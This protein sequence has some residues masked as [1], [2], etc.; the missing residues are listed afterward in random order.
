MTDRTRPAVAGFA[1]PANAAGASDAAERDTST[2]RIPLWS[3]VQPI[4]ALWFAA[5][6]HSPDARAQRMLAHWRTG[7]KALRFADGDLL[8]FPEPQLA[9]CETQ[10]G[11]VLC[12]DPRIVTHGALTSA[13]LRAEDLETVDFRT[14]EAAT[15]VIA[16]T[17]AA[18]SCDLLL[19]HGARVLGLRQAD[20]AALDLSQWIDIDAYA[21]HDTFDCNAAI[22]TPDV[23]RLAGRDVRD[24]LGEKIP[25]PS[26]EREAF[27]ER[28]SERARDGRAVERS[29]DISVGGGRH[30]SGRA[31]EGH[32]GGGRLRAIGQ[33]WL[34]RIAAGL[35]GGLA[36]VGEAPGMATGSAGRHGKAGGNDA[37]S[38]RARH[39][40]VAPSRWREALTRL[41][42]ASR[43]S[44]L[45]GWRQGAYLRKMLQMFEDGDLNE[46][47]RHAL[48]IDA[49]GPSRGQAFSAPGR[50]NQL[51]LSGASDIGTDIGLPDELR[52]HLRT[53]YRQ[54]FERLDRAG[55]IDE[56]LFVLA[57]LLNAKQEALD[58]LERHGRHVQAAELALAWDMP[59]ATI[60]R[61]L[62]LAGD[63]ERA[64]QVARRDGDFASAVAALEKTKPELA[65]KLRLAWGE[66]LAER[67]QWLT[68]METVWPIPQAR[69]LALH[70]LQAAEAA[71]ERLS[72]RALV[73]RAEH[74]PDTLERYGERLL[75]LADP[76]TDADARFAVTRALLETKTH[77]AATRAIAAAIAPALLADRAELRHDMSKANLRQV[78][79]LSE[80]P[81]LR[82]DA[83]EVSVPAVKA[84]AQF[85]NAAT[86]LRWDAP[87]VGLRAVHDVA[88][89][90]DHRYLVALGEAG[91]AV[92]DRR[93]KTVQSYAVPAYA[94][95]IGHSR[96]IALATAPRETLARVTRLDL[97]HHTA[98]DL[99]ATPVAFCAD[100]FDG[101]GWSVVSRNRI[102]VI[103]A[104]KSLHDVLWH[105]GDL[106]G[107]IVAARYAAGHE[108]YLIRSGNAFE[109]WNYDLSG[110]RLIS[111]E[112]VEL[113]EDALP[114]LYPHGQVLQL[115]VTEKAEHSFEIGYDWHRQ[116]RRVRLGIPAGEMAPRVVCQ[117]LTQGFLLG[118]VGERSARYGLYR[119]WDARCMAEFD[120]PAS[121]ALRMRE[122]PD[123][124]L[125]FDE[126]G[127]ILA[128]DSDGTLRDAIS[129]H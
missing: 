38:I 58:Y 39:E 60:V 74:L 15:A 9:A 93:G 54:S 22:P 99:G 17:A 105:V 95:A 90:D 128:L 18:K 72:A 118:V 16:G 97:V 57:E 34:G 6:L 7:A 5:D 61:L 44:R 23:K 8:R 55:K 3:G 119:N 103:D 64:V 36:A 129:V 43:M 117:A 96:N 1:H 14:A 121:A 47:L 63:W 98:T 45:I 11:L 62:L 46:A 30:G 107:P 31:G 85:W 25:P 56:A 127:R 112:R 125:I 87:A 91:A 106:P 4:A 29:A 71:G 13:P 53:L 100:I 59:A 67:G 42:I 50:R 51:S 49:T 66:A 32:A 75:A 80:D 92:I 12:F 86:P 110:R 73:R 40:P 83:P 76:D 111:R 79:H 77:N 114:L 24:L 35:L 113:Q 81:W 82:A 20:G 68:A 94:L 78:L 41:A 120:W 84:K 21:L 37:G 116:T 108:M 48:P 26:A 88:M 10:P 124:M 89:L 70:W 122:L 101:I 115:R 109:L 2:V 102:L 19:V 28:L 69:N 33:D 123:A 27:L 104:A 126:E 52:D 65:I